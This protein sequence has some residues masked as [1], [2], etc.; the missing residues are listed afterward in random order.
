M[1]DSKIYLLNKFADDLNGVFS[2][3]DLEVLYSKNPLSKLQSQRKIKSLV[4]NKELI[5]IKRGVYAKPNASLLDIV[6]RI[7]P[8]SYISTGYV[9][10]KNTLIGSV[11]EKKIQA[12]KLG[13]PRI[14]KSELGTIE[15]LSI[16][17]DLF[18]GYKKINNI[19]IALPEKAFLD[20]CYYYFKGKKFSF[21]IQ[22]DID[23]ENLDFKL[24]EEYLKKY[25][26]K[27]I[28]FFKKLMK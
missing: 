15:F 7:N 8:D 12:I 22:S 26:I 13:R 4:E 9:L 24:I 14:F 19:N 20:V 21:N 27:F 3:K 18:F 6:K 10:A 23:F 17:K 1:S 28:N 16:K 11:P 25:D 2:V 5:K